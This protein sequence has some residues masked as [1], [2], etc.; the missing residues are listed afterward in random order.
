MVVLFS[1]YLLFGLFLFLNQKSFIYYP[2]KQDFNSCKEFSDAEKIVVNGTKIYF[3]NNSDIMVV[4]YHGNAGSACDRSFIKNQIEKVGYSYA[5]V[6]YAGYSN[7]TKKTSKNRI[8]KDV[9][10]TNSFLLQKNYKEIIVIG[11]S[12]GTGPASYHSSISHVSKLVLISPFNKLSDVA[13]KTYSLYPLSILLTEN[14]DNEKWLKYYNG[15]VLIIH[16]DKDT[17]VPS[18]LSLKLFNTLTAKDKQ[19]KIINGASHND[20]YNYEETF[21]ELELFLK[22]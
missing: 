18:D 7:D 22:K 10:N 11:E 9:E 2:D 12:I 6:E 20:I 21:N 1:L 5:F 14:Y 15:A 3:K 17:F 8:L 16:G 19:Y 13:K 4:F